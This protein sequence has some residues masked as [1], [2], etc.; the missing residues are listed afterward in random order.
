[1]AVHG[2]RGGADGG[3]R[4]RIGGCDGLG[5]ELFEALCQFRRTGEGG[6]HRNLLVQEHTDQEGERVCAEQAVRSI[7]TGEPKHRHAH[8]LP[9]VATQRLA[10][11]A[12]TA[13]SSSSYAA[14][15]LCCGP[16]FQA[17]PPATLS[18]SLNT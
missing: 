4:F 14:R 1:E 2:R 13:P 18:S 5:A 9:Q 12:E 7:V 6:L 16:K 17:P 3:E 8:R 10:R 11:P 15:G